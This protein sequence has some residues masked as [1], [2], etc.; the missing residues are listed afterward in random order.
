MDHV[1]DDVT[2][3]THPTDSLFIISQRLRKDVLVVDLRIVAGLAGTAHATSGSWG[4][5]TWSGRR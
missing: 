1:A 5:R 3:P 4:S 2:N